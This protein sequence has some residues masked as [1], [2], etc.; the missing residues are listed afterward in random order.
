MLHALRAFEAWRG[1]AASTGPAPI[2]LQKSAFHPLW[3]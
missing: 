1:T 3:T 2:K